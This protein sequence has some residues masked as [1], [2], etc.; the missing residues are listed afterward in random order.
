LPK[1][2]TSCHFKRNSSSIHPSACLQVTIQ[3]GHIESG[4]QLFKLPAL[5][6][7]T[8]SVFST[9]S[10]DVPERDK[11]FPYP[12]IYMN[13][14]YIFGLFSGLLGDKKT[15]TFE[16]RTFNTVM[17]SVGVAGLALLSYD[18][19]LGNIA[20]QIIDISCIVYSMSCYFYSLKSCNHNKLVITTFIFLYIAISSGW[21]FNNGIHGGIP[22]FFFVLCCYSG[23]FFKKPFLNAIPLII[24][25]VLFLSIIE[26]LNPDIVILY[27][28]RIHNFLDLGASI[29]ICLVISGVSIHIIYKKYDIERELNKKMLNQAISDKELIESSIKEIQILRGLL[30]ICS[31]CKKI[32]DDG[33][34]WMQLEKFIQENSEAKFSHSMCPE[35]ARSVYPDFLE[36]INSLKKTS[37]A[38]R[39]S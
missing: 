16:N 11:P 35:C 37:H 34:E 36:K 8:D 5:P 6:V 39:N 13:Y 27:K 4:S 10:P 26:F 17:L 15:Q 14:K 21:F 23:I 2:S 22:F 9:I 7:V 32:R 29:I 33:G 25:T 3:L 12:F 20:S 18:I 30:P 38:R 28:S 31:Y 19:I 1:K 24:V